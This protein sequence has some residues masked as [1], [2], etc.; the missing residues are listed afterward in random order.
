MLTNQLTT[1]GAERYVVAVS[2]WLSEH[3]VRVI[4]AATPGELVDALAPGVVYHPT[5]LQDLRAEIPLAAARVARLI[6][7][8]RPSVIVANSMIT[9]W[10]ARLADPLRR[11][12]VVA[13]AHGWPAERYRWVGL[14]LRVA[15]RVVPVSDDVKR[16]LVAAG[17]PEARCHVIPNGIDLSPFGPRTLE[18]VQAARAALGAGPQDVVVI[19]VGR[20]VA[21]KAQHRIFEIAAR[22]ERPGLRFV[23]VGWG[24]REQELRAAARDVRLL[25]RRSDVPDLL[26]ASDVFLSVSDWEGMPLSMIEAMAAGLPVVSTAVEGIGDLVNAENGRLCPPGDVSALTAAV[27]ELVDDEPL[28]L[29]LG[30]ES[31]ARVER[32]FSV[33]VMCRRLLALLDDVVHAG[34]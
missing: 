30:A 23:I 18:Q 27:A 11:V 15:D 32:A 2:R 19:N 21:Q 7:R 20:F 22:L 12:P 4:V 33:D 26:L 31:R 9:A 5:A 3:G 1:G 25:V 10:V 28:R 24:E 14:P 17:L 13:V 29:R 6:R 8:H 16:R 34:R